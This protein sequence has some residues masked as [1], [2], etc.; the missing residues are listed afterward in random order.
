MLAVD[1]IRIGKE[2]RQDRNIVEQIPVVVPNALKKV[3]ENAVLQEIQSNSGDKALVSH[4]LYVGV[5]KVRNGA[6]HFEGRNYA[7]RV[8]RL[9][10]KNHRL[11][12]PF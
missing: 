5:N 4:D 3:S 8:F 12:S 1:H 6:T 9:N 7:P 10:H 11:K 2:L